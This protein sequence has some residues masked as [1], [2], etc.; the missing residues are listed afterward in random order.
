[1]NGNSSSKVRIF[2]PI[3]H[4]LQFLTTITARRV[5]GDIPEDPQNHSASTKTTS[6]R[7][8]DSLQPAASPPRSRSRRSTDVEA[9]LHPAAISAHLRSSDYHHER[10]RRFSSA[11]Q[12]S[13]LSPA[14]SGSG[15][16]RRLSGNFNAPTP[17]EL[18]RHKDHSRRARGMGKLRSAV[19]GW[20]K[21]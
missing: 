2:F 14:R 15:E 20:V 9:P 11:E 18:E 5:M 21:A 16:I 4:V 3:H 6:R 10:P 17:I 7:R 13:L 8:A 19:K 1:M 12:Y